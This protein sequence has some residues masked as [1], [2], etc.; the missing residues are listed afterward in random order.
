MCLDYLNGV[1]R[2]SI[3]EG[4]I[5]SSQSW[6]NK[7]CRGSLQL[8][9]AVPSSFPLCLGSHAGFGNAWFGLSLPTTDPRVSVNQN[10]LN[11]VGDESLVV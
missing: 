11:E 7:R 2:K 3:M 6:P 9:K 8:W 10:P 5:K 1:A 4:E